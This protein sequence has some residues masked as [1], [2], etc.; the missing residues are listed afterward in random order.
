MLKLAEARAKLP[1]FPGNGTSMTSMPHEVLNRLRTL[2]QALADLLTK[3][4]SLHRD[5]PE[6]WILAHMIRQLRN[7]IACRGG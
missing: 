7:E 5:H 3:Y 2:P 6:R 4:N 1:C